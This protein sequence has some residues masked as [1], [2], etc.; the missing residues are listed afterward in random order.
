MIMLDN[1]ELSR[2]NIKPVGQ[3]SIPATPDVVNKTMRIPGADI[4]WDFGTEWGPRP[5]TI[6]LLIEEEDDYQ[7]QWLIR[8]FV[9]FLMDSYGRPRILKLSRNV[10]P[11]K[12]Y[13]VKLNQRIDPENL[14]R[15]KRFELSFVANQPHAKFIVP[16][17]QISWDSDIPIM[18]SV[19]WA[20]EG[21]RFRIYQAQSI[22][23][24]YSGTRAIRAGFKLQGS[25]TNVKVSANG[26]T[27][28]FGNMRNTTFDVDGESYTIKQD[29]E[30][31]LLSTEFIEL[32]HG[33]N[34]VSIS[35]SNLNL[36]FSEQ[37]TYQ[38]I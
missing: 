27:M 12:Y 30:D 24:V 32:H 1:T 18:N 29:G 34:R 38:F 14:F 37:L 26:K 31:R 2:W 16:S 17:N 4:T 21:T 7:R 9:A 22:N 15:R 10:E 6:P 8:E 20:M 19:L 35:G 36:T 13:E 33:E 3:M 28:S 5:L 11:D 25:G 23:L